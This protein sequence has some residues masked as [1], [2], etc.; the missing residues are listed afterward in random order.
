MAK[1]TFPQTELETRTAVHKVRLEHGFKTADE[2]LIYL[3]ERDKYASEL[4]AE[5]KKLRNRLDIMWNEAHETKLPH[6]NNEKSWYDLRAEIMK[7]DREIETLKKILEFSECDEQEWQA[8][9]EIFNFMVKKSEKLKER[10]KELE[11]VR[12]C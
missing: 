8:H 5:N 7:K 2:A 6:P 10:L 1:V 9:K 12:D 4:E 11:A 3:I